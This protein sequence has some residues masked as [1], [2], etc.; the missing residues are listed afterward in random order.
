MR[1]DLLLPDVIAVSPVVASGLPPAAAVKSPD[2]KKSVAL[3]RKASKVALRLGG[4][5][6]RI[7][8]LTGEIYDAEN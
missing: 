8:V 2:F 5:D 3:A 4:M 6:T 7:N 1:L